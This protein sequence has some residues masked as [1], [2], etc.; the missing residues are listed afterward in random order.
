MINLI[1]EASEKIRIE[2]RGGYG[3]WSYMSVY[4]YLDNS[5]VA[6]IDFQLN[7]DENEIYI[8]MIEVS[9][10]YRRQGIAAKMFSKLR[11]EYPD[12]YV[13]CG[14]T[15]EDGSKLKDALTTTIEN[16]DYINIE[17][18]IESIDSQLSE[19]ESVLNDDDWLE[20]NRDKIDE[21]GSQ[22]ESLYDRKRDLQ[23]ELSDV[24]QYITMWK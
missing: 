2:Y 16:Q 23:D 10:D 24:R 4:Y 21:L 13:D 1:L 14:Y 18:E 6:Y 20:R 3:D 19:L 11:S 22:W 7:E 9:K 5:C 17:K 8:E 12:Y 15:L